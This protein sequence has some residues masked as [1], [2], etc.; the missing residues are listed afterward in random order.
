M[1]SSLVTY[2]DSL[3]YVLYVPRYRGTVEFN[4]LL[5]VL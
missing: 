4:I 2:E 3:H 1:H 5:D